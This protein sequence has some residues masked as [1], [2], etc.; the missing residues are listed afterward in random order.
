MKAVR[1]LALAA[2][3]LVA[4]CNPPAPP[5]TSPAPAGLTIEKV[6]A[7]YQEA[8]AFAELLAP[9]LSAE[10][11]LQLAELERRI[12]AAI[13]AAKAARTIAEQLR[14]LREAQDATAQLESG[15]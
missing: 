7:A 9:Y 10:R 1:L 5:E 2:A 12:E 6:E 8:K 14:A 3:L 13:A 15:Q 4:G 11:V